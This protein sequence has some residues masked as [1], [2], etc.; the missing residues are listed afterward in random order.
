MEN[1]QLQEI[2]QKLDLVMEY[3]TEQRQ[4]NEMFEDLLTDISIIGKDAFQSSVT[5]LDQQGIELDGEALKLLFFKSLKNVNNF[6]MILDLFESMVDLAKDLGPV[7]KETGYDVINK[8]HDLDQKGYFEFF[9]E[10]LKIWD[11]IITHYS[12]EDVR[13]LADNIV[14]IMDT[15]KNLTQPDML[16]AMNNAVNIFKGLDPTQV[17]EYSVWKIIREMNSPEMKRGMGFIITFLKNLTPVEQE[18]NN[19]K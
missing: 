14:T 7:V 11:N 1:D 12:I 5:E 17:P 15:M 2:N 9:G 16:D 3:M 13:L 8:F 6:S 10:T 4:K 18:N 19:K